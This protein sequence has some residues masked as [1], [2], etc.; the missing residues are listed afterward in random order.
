MCGHLGFTKHDPTCHAVR[1]VAYS[2]HAL[3]EITSGGPKFANYSVSDWGKF[4]SWL[5]GSVTEVNHSAVPPSA[6]LVDP[7]GVSSYFVCDMVRTLLTQ[8]PNQR[9]RGTC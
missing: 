2:M 1:A 7:Q 6:K 9:L 4:P 8:S 3:R 5:D